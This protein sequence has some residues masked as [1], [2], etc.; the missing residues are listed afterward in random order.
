MTSCSPTELSFRSLAHSSSTAVLP[1]F[2]S[3]SRT[4]QMIPCSHQ[5]LQG[6][7][8]VRSVWACWVWHITA[9]SRIRRKSC[10]QTKDRTLYTGRTLLC[11]SIHEGATG[12]ERRPDVGPS[13]HPDQ[14]NGGIVFKNCF[15]LRMVFRSE[16]QAHLVIHL[17]M[18]SSS[19]QSSPG[20]KARCN[21]NYSCVPITSDLD[22]QQHHN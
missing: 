4:Y 9:S 13:A 12:H 16:R 15:N 22:T 14:A 20:W 2:K 19:S 5:R 10:L 18:R 7:V 8:L 6:A 1:Q 3:L 21:G 17:V 11:F